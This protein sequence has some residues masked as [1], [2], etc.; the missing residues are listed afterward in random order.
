MFDLWSSVP[1]QQ[2]PVGGHLTL[3]N[4]SLFVAGSSGVNC[5]DLTSGF[6]SHTL[7]IKGSPVQL[8]TPKPDYGSYPVV[9]EAPLSLRIDSASITNG[10]TRYV[11]AGWSGTGSLASSG[12]NNVVNFTATA[13]TTITWIWQLEH[14][15]ELDAGNGGITGAVTG[16]KPQ[17]YV[18]DLYPTNAFGYVFDHWLT[19]GVEA[20]LTVPLRITI[21]DRLQVK[22]VFSPAFIDVTDLTQSE[23][24]NWKLNRQT[25]TYLATLTVSNP[26]NSVKILTEPFWFVL[27]PSPYA[28]LMHPD[29]VEPVNGWP[30]SDITKRMTEAIR[31]VGDGDLALDPGESVLVHDIEVFSYDRSIPVGYVYGIWADPPALYDIKVNFD[32]DGDG[33]PNLWEDKF[34][35]LSPNNPYDANGDDD[36]DGMS[37]FKEYFSD[38]DPTDS[39]SVMRIRMI[40]PASDGVQL[41]WTGGV[42]AKQIIE[43][44]RDLK[45]WHPCYTNQTP[46]CITNAIHMTGN[47]GALFFRIR[48]EGR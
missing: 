35:N 34:A 40:Q 32:T 42:E 28:C 15:L 48:T 19:N 33:I 13:N 4:D 44:S 8:K 9:D 18:Y 41:S 26:S 29:G 21:G 10:L 14:W 5:F 12:T 46:T 3:A 16:W 47:E 17:G 36:G 7:E 6:I 43:F 11:F 2:L 23:I 31:L 45:V 37:N 24:V 27:K 20:G 22:A 1:R 39:E 30:Y 25:G 38:T